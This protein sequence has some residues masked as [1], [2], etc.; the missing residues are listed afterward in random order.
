MRLPF[1]D[2][3]SR[4]KREEMAAVDLG[5]RTTKAVHLQRRGEGFALCGYALLD[6]PIFEKTLSAE[7]LAEHLKA[8]A[9]ALQLKSKYVTL[10]LRVD[11]A[12]VRHADIPRLPLSDMRMVLKLSPKTYLQ[13]DL[14]G[15]VFDC[16]ISTRDHQPKTTEKPRTPEGSPKERVLVVGAR[17]QILDDLVRGAKAAG[18]VAECITP[19]LIGPVNTFERAMPEVFEKQ[20]V[21]LVDIGFKYSSICIVREGELVLSRVVGIGGDRITSGL[22]ENLNI[23]YA[24]AEGIKV[25]MPGEVQA[26]IES[27]LLPLGRE[28]R[29]SMD[30]FEHQ[31]DCPISQVFLTGGSSRSE[32]IVQRLK[33]EL[34]V[35]C[36]ILSPL[37][38]LQIQLS[39]EQ[40]SEI[41]QIASQLSVAVGA[42]LAA[43]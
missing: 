12:Q 18:L 43:L 28:L 22:A 40:T 39:P 23:S 24:E 41:E 38:F 27:L 26:Q 15:H 11:D 5:S 17:Q 31:H 10:A 42:G 21:A 19:G 1:I 2:S 8:V 34:M 14:P 36:K 9:Q 3:A 30:F 4:P 35:D 29:A 6:A 32:F 7:L 16:H 13:Q 25:G 37:A 33:Q 20:A